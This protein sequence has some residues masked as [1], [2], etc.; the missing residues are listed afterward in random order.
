MYITPDPSE[1]IDDPV[2]EPESPT[3]PSP[4]LTQT[5]QRRTSLSNNLR[6]SPY[7]TQVPD[8]SFPPL[9]SGRPYTH[10]QPVAFPSQAPEAMVYGVIE[11]PVPT[12]Q[13]I[14]ASHRA[15][16]ASAAE[17]VL[18]Q[19]RNREKSSA[20]AL[21]SPRH[22]WINNY[23]HEPVADQSSPNTTTTH[24]GSDTSTGTHLP[25]SA[26]QPSPTK[27][28]S[29][30]RTEARRHSL[31]MPIAPPSSPVAAKVTL[32]PSRVNRISRSPSTPHLVQ[33]GNGQSSSPTVPLGLQGLLDGEHH[34][35]ELSVRFE[36]GWPL[37]EQWLLTIGRGPG[38]G[39][40]GRVVI[41]Y[42]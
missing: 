23:Q 2:Y 42:K 27:G 10:T 36:A 9:L 24:T 30:G 20:T 19:I 34:T 14:T 28:V 5:R 3:D 40:Y 11:P 13:P 15:R 8:E 35:D 33:S 29:G 41:V 6:I 16:R 39:D 26:S 7:G 37:L 21:P 32:T 12:A 22:S 38:D 18:E 4:D 1:L 17:K 31:I 25:P